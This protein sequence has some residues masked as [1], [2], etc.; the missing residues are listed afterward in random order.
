MFTFVF[1]LENNL[2]LWNKFS[3]KKLTA[4]HIHLCHSLPSHNLE[5]L[6]FNRKYW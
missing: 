6:R 4:F 1:V 5:Q 3:K 2:G